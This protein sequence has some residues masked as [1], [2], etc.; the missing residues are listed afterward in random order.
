MKQYRPVEAG[1]IIKKLDCVLGRL[2]AFRETFVRVF[3][4]SLRWLKIL[5]IDSIGRIRQDQRHEKKIV[6]S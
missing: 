1:S 6:I 3:F 2:P 5:I 4:F